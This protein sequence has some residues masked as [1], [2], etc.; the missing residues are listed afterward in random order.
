M[1]SDTFKWNLGE[2]GN[3]VIKDFNLAPVTSGGDVLDL[4]DLLTG[5]S[6]NATSLDAYLNFSANG[7]G[8]TLITV[9]ANGAADGGTGQTI[10]LENIS[11]ASLQAY[12]GGGGSDIDIITKLLA[13]G[14][15]KTDP[16]GP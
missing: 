14:N 6:A 10:T 4:K 1:G 2:T 3:D 16:G 11:F 15:L 13:G 5:E 12:A 7:L 9:D 8:Q